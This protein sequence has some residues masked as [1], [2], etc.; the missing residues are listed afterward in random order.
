MDSKN[1]KVKDGAALATLRF[2]ATKLFSKEAELSLELL[3]GAE[4]TDRM[5]KSFNAG[6][7]IPVVAIGIPDIFALRQNYPNPFN[8]STTIQYDLPENGKVT[9]TVYNSLGQRVGTL[10]NTKQV[11]GAYEVNF[12]ASNLASGVYLYRVTVEGSKNFVM[13]KKMI[14]MK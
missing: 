4:I 2:K 8:P 3:D 9:L 10:V 1:I 12:N 6:I 13:T 7:K 5:A 11:A 14:L